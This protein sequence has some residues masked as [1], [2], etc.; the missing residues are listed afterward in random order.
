MS[1]METVAIVPAK[2]RA[3]SIVATVQ[4]LAALESLDRVIVVD[5]GSHDATA[6]L[7]LGTGCCEVV[8]LRQNRGKGGAV[9]AGIDA[10]RDAAI[11]VLID[12]DLGA[13]AVIAETL[14]NAVR[15]GEADM[16]IGV[17]DSAGAGPGASGGFGLVKRLAAWGILRGSGY[18]TTAPL[19]GQ[20]AISGP[21]ARTL[22]EAPG[23]AGRFGLETG[24]TID[25]V[26]SGARVLEVEV[27]FSHRA[28]GRSL[29]GFAHRGR[30][31]ADIARA[32]WTRLASSR[33]WGI[34]L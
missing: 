11:Y 18:R 23:F 12:A 6:E 13:S 5:D 30:Q 10:A 31:G 15:N 26:R 2:D 27:S 17:P 20:R 4:A 7:A 9:A 1:V 32:L 3:D 28:T 21:L 8:S 24:L 14:I 22:R 34:M 25:A 33:I 29:A 19:S 16:A